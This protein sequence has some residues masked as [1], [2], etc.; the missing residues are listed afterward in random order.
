MLIPLIILLPIVLS[1][2]TKNETT[3]PQSN[4]ITYN[5][6]EFDEVYDQRQNGSENYRLN[7]DGVVLVWSPPGGLLQAASLLDPALFE[8]EYPDLEQILN[9]ENAEKPQDLLV[10]KP[11][12]TPSVPNVPVT[13]NNLE[14]EAPSKPKQNQNI[15]KR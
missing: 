10:V 11:E 8:G 9:Q 1:A 3:L 2:P 7:V 14:V 5:I 4:E 15:Q 13:E 6:S 12:T